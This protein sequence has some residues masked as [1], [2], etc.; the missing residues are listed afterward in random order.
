[1]CD[2]KEQIIRRRCPVNPDMIQFLAL[3]IQVRVQQSFFYLLPLCILHVN[4]GNVH[5][6]LIITQDLITL[7][8]HLDHG[9]QLRMHL[10][11]IF[12]RALQ[13]YKIHTVI[14]F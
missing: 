1:M 8:T 5:L 4:D 10:K 12:D 9:F 6:F 14:E 3:L 2:I 13:T 11:H 7:L